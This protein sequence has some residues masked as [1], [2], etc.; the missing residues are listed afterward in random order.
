MGQTEHSAQYINMG[1][2]NSNFQTTG[3]GFPVGGKVTIIK[4][5]LAHG[6]SCILRQS[7]E[8]WTWPNSLREQGCCGAALFEKC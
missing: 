5:S 7:R 2:N 1:L 4:P 6:G 3:R 8:N